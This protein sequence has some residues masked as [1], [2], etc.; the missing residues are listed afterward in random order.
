M[1]GT[2]SRRAAARRSR[3]FGWP[4]QDAAA[5]V[6]GEQ[7]AGGRGVREDVGRLRAEASPARAVRERAH[8][9]P[10]ARAADALVLGP[11]R[12]RQAL[13][14]GGALGL[15]RGQR[16]AVDLLLGVDRRTALPG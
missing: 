8:R 13:D 16:L 4:Y 11:G 9:A 2:R 7:T 6:A 10:G 12:R 1:P 14:P 3:G 15:E 5:A